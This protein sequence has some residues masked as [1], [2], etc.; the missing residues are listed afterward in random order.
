MQTPA[1][2]DGTQWIVQSHAAL[3]QS[4]LNRVARWLVNVQR[5]RRLETIPG[6]KRD[7]LDKTIRALRAGKIVCGLTGG[8]VF[9]ATVGT[10]KIIS[11]GAR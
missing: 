9:K 1:Y 5:Q 7:E 2:W 4:Q 3:S 11:L 6:A 8:D 10:G